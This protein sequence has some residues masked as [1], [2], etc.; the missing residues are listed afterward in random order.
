MTAWKFRAAAQMAV[1]LLLV[2]GP[3][4]CSDEGNPLAGSG[5]GGATLGDGGGLGTGGAASG[6]SGSDH[7]SG[8]GGSVQSHGAGGVFGAGGAADGGSAAVGG[9]AAGGSDGAG[10]RTTAELGAA[11]VWLAGDSTMANGNTPCPVGWGKAFDALF[12]ERIT[13]VNSAVGGRSV[14]T[15]LYD[16]Q[17]SKDT[18]GECVLGMT[19]G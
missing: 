2:V 10:G 6:G 15:W 7:V 18:S 4:A 11:T 16:V 13:V 17:D 19:N 1:P 9:A 12:D 3:A 5:G 8:V 14:R